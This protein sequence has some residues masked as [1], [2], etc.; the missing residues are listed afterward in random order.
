MRWARQMRGGEGPA[1]SLLRGP[2]SFP[3]L[4]GWILGASKGAPWWMK[5]EWITTSEGGEFLS[6]GPDIF[7]AYLSLALEAYRQLG[8]DASY[9]G[10]VPLRY[11][12]F[13]LLR[14]ATNKGQGKLEDFHLEEST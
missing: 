6:G 12:Q 14:T 8:Y 13:Q 4:K 1:D 10:I 2:G 11:T 9:G 7:L 3:F 5:A